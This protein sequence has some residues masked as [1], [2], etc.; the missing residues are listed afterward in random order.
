M[1]TLAPVQIAEWLSKR[2]VGQAEAV[3][4]MSVALAK[5]LAGLGAGNILMIGSS[6]SG[7]TTLMQAVE[8]MLASSP[9]LAT[10]STVVRIHA[11]VLGEE[12]EQG[13][14]GA[15]LLLRLLARARQQLGAEAP[16]ERLLQ[17]AS[18]GLVFVDEVD[19]IRSHVGGAGTSRASA[20]RKPCSR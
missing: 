6:G 20:P 7:K 10:R 17:Q 8:A 1:A 11:N 12:V 14:P 19:K 9:A 5:K 16:V 18:Q 15:R 4:E 2:V 3:R 13:Q